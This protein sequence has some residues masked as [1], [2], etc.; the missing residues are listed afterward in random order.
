MYLWGMASR[1]VYWRER[2]FYVAHGGEA[3]MIG[4]SSQVN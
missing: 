4:R 1:I 2:A 3:T